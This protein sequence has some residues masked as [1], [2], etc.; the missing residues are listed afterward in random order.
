MMLS[1]MKYAIEDRVCPTTSVRLFD[2]DATDE[3]ATADRRTDDHAQDLAFVGRRH[4]FDHAA[5]EVDQPAERLSGGDLVAD[6]DFRAEETKVSRPY[7]CGL[8]E[9][10]GWRNVSYGSFDDV[11]A[12]KHVLQAAQHPFGDGAVILPGP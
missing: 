2:S 7:P 4:L 5:M 6:L 12:A 9:S 8:R 10:P 1:A 11:Q 3:T